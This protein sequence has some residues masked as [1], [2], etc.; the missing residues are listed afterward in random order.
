M[1]C[2]GLYP[3]RQPSDDQKMS[4]LDDSTQNTPKNFIRQIIDKDLAA[5]LHDSVVT[6]FPPE[7]NGYLHIAM[8]N[9]FA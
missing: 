7:P 3:V 4:N 9:P 2:A 6:R 1:M 8:L 5:G